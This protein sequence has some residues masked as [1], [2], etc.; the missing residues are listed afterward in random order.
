MVASLLPLPLLAQDSAPSAKSSAVKTA[1][2]SPAKDDV[3]YPKLV[4]G[5]GDLLQIQVYGENGSSGEGISV[6]TQLPTEYQVDS[7]GIIVFPFL[8]RVNLKGMTPV[9]AGEHLA[10]E[11]SKP[12]KVTVLIKESNTY[13][14]SVLGNVAR[15]GRYQIQGKP[16]LLSALAQ[17]GGPLP[18]TDYGG[19]ILIHED[20][21]TKLDL[22][23]YL[24]GE[25]KMKPEPYLFPGD[26]LMVAKSG[27]PSIGEIAIVASILASAAVVT[28]ELQNLHH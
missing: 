18:E 13:W 21:K 11:L 6:N 20:F 26:T 10:I 4:I 16:S 14:V 27:W 9:Q 1:P 17:A 15:P 5:P 19:A 7:E 24:Q 22:N 8:G 28:V 2:A 25:G 23:N 3:D 12:R